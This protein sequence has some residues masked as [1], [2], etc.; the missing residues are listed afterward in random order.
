MSSNC[1]VRSW[2]LVLVRT[3]VKFFSFDWLLQTK[4]EA[5]SAVIESYKY[6]NNTAICPL[7]GART[8]CPSMAVRKELLLQDQT[9][10]LLKKQIQ[11][12]VRLT[13]VC[14]SIWDLRA[15]GNRLAFSKQHFLDTNSGSHIKLSESFAFGQAWHDDWGHNQAADQVNPDRINIPYLTCGILNL[16]P[17]CRLNQTQ[18]ERAEMDNFEKLLTTQQVQ[19]QISSGCPEL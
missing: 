5:L 15:S 7:Q 8:T 6:H 19:S 3:S 17:L 2:L 1:L 16:L 14:Q 10:F 4:L 12:Q 18:L 9:I 13:A 11:D